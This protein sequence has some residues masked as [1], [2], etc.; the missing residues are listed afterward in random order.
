MKPEFI[1][2]IEARMN[3][4]RLYG[5]VLKNIGDKYNSLRLIV[6]RIR[7]HKLNYK[8]IIVTSKKK[9]NDEIKKLADKLGVLCY[10]GSEE[11]VLQRLCRSVKNYSENSIIQLTGDNPLIDFD[12]V[13]YLVKFYKKYYPNIDF[14]TNNNLFNKTCSSPLGMKA[15]I[16]KK[17]SLLQIEYLANKK[18]LKEHPTLFFYREGK[19]KFIIKNL[20][21]PKKWRLE[22]NPRLTIDTNEDL[23][24]IRNIF[25]KLNFKNNFKIRDIKTILSKYPRLLSINK[26]ILQKIPKN[27]G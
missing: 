4:K 27:L 8:I 16:I 14:L 17:S 12:L 20:K 13:K 26:S 18:D 5:K 22:S 6:E 15:S 7:L 10:R 3:S 23:I 19:E 11:N 2:T 1:I 9:E 25:K 24:F 21:I